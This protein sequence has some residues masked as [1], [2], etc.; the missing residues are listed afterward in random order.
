MTEQAGYKIVLTDDVKPETQQEYYQF[1]M[2]QYV[3]TIQS[4]GF[5]MSEAWHTAY[6]NAPNRLIGFVCR[7]RQTMDNLLDNE[8]WLEL[9]EQLDQFV[10]NFSY[11]VMPYKQ[12]F[13]I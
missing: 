3:P 2:G 5:Q 6:G 11:K 12:G 10:T 7:S 9:N 4:M 1:V 8:E 13:Q